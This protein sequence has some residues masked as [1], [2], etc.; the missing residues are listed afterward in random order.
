M[1]LGLAI[2]IAVVLVADKIRYQEKHR[3]S[4]A[5][6]KYEACLTWELEDAVKQ[7]NQVKSE[8]AELQARNVVK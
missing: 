3:K 6:Y 4:W 1:L 7:F 8:L 5:D 2:I